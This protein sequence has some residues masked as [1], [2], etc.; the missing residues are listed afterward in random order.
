MIGQ[1]QTLLRVKHLKQEQSFRELQKK[2]QA[3]EAAMAETRAAEAEVAASLA[4]LASREDAIFGALLGRT[5]KLDDLEDAKGR[6]LDLL[7]THG[8][9]EDERDRARHVEARTRTE[10]DAA[11]ERYRAATKVRDKYGI[12]TDDLVR[13]RDE[14]V[15]YREEAEVEEMFAKP[16]RRPE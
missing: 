14:E 15:A 11:G 8:I 3:N 13:V 1:M 9:L 6:A 7:K 2:R 10:L 4:T 16:G 12:L 5:V